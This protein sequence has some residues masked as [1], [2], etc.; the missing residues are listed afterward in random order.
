MVPTE[1]R[2]VFTK[3]LPTTERLPVA[4]SL[5]FT[6]SLVIN[7]HLVDENMIEISTSNKFWSINNLSQDL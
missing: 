7:K 2:L 4:K 3:S 6:K 5:P 1:K